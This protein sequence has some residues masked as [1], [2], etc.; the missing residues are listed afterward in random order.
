MTDQ[1]KFE[2]FK[3]KLID[4]NEQK[5]GKEVRKKYGDDTVN[6]SNAKLK[7]MTQEQYEEGERLL[8]EFN[9]TIKVALETA[10]PDPAGELAQKACELHKQWL[11]F[12]SPEYSKEYHKNLGEMYVADERFRAYY[13]QVAEGCAKFLRDALIIFCK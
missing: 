6:N 3:Q 4:E 9:N 5:Y 13:D 11:C 10:N 12:Y 1:E 7:G 2:G 8:S